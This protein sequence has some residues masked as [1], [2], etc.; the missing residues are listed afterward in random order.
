M[1]EILTKNHSMS[2]NGEDLVSKNN[3]NN[4]S[5]EEI[6]ESRVSRRNV[7]KGSLA[8]VAGSFLGINLI[9]CNSNNSVASTTTASSLEP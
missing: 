4:L 3:S 7:I 9:G 2:P 1:K 8:M 6:I 5:L